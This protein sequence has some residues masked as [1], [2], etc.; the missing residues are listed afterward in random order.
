[1]KLLEQYALAMGLK[2][3]KPFIYTAFYPLPF[4]KYITIH[5]SS[6]M[7]AKNYSFWEDVLDLIRP[8][9]I[10]QDIQIVQIGGPDDE[11]LKGCYHLNG[12]TNV[13]QTAYVLSNSKFHLSNDT[14]SAHV[15]GALNIPQVAIYGATTVAN[16]AP[17][18][19]HDVSEFIEADRKGNKPSYA[20]KET[21]R[22]INNIKPEQIASVVLG[23]A[24]NHTSVYFGEFYSTYIIECVPDHA[25]PA[26]QLANG[27]VNVRMD[28]HFDEGHLAQM[29]YSRKVNVITN[30]PINL[31]LIRSFKHNVNF[32]S[33]ELDLSTDAQY[34]Y[35]LKSTGVNV[36]LITRETDPEKLSEIRLKFF[37]FEVSQELTGTKEALD[38][39]GN[40]GYNTFY[41]TNKF[42][43]SKDGI[44]LSKADWLRKQSV[45]SFENN[46]R[47]IVDTPEFWGEA[48]YF[49]IFN[50]EQNG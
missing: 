1:M 13:N 12:V 24:V 38:I 6:G 47:P 9:L 31:N 3:N 5:P 30:K 4:Q 25:L 49:Y 48:D 32:I 46:I 8:A 26:D 35:A 37:D 41:K 20:T 45:A 19:R 17:Y 23:K 34:V 22:T 29:A 10:E 14:F 16:H 39:S 15:A 40:V 42:L 21:P 33:F 28:Y 27:I 7:E 44:F 18:H 43:L 11:K 2:I 50:K 36:A